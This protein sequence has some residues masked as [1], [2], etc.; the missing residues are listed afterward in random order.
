MPLVVRILM[1]VAMLPFALAPAARA[2]DASAYVVSYVEVLPD[3]SGQALVLLKATAAASRM[4]DGYL[5][6]EVLQQIASPHRFAILET[7]KDAKAQEAH[8]SSAQTKA[9]RESLGAVQASPYDERV[10]IALAVGAAKP[11][12]AGAVYAVTHVD[13]IGPRKDDGMAQLKLVSAPSRQEAGSLRFDALQ[14]ASRP[15]HFTIVAVW[16]DEKAVVEHAMA[17]HTRQFRAALQPMIGSPYDE[18]LYEVVNGP[19]S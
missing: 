1:A 8:A 10:H 3:A 17:A 9:W 16:R 15:N 6:F 13:C 2:E 5:R 19:G 14:Q 12:A 7:W 4:E 11:T 18:R